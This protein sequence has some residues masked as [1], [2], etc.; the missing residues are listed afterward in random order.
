MKKFDRLPPEQR[1]QE[2]CT[3]ALRLFRE[4]GFAA[5]TMENIVSEVSLSKGGVYRIYPSTAAILS[6]LILQGMHL[7]N[8]FYLEAVRSRLAAGIAPDA[9]FVADTIVESLLQF[10]AFSEVYVEFL[11]EKRRNPELETLY[12]QI[13]ETTAKETA[14]LIGSFGVPPDSEGFPERMKL[15]ADAMNAAILSIHVLSL[16]DAVTEKKEMLS[17][18]LLRLLQ[19]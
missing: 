13:Y 18:L 4:K 16:R 6:D 14:A 9:K 2:I 5:T 19:N 7:R 1:R 11:W 12:Q 15:L 17:E 10:Q 8:D 3:A